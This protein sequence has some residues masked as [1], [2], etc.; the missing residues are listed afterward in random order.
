LVLGGIFLFSGSPCLG[1]GI[2]KPSVSTTRTVTTVVVHPETGK[3][4]RVRPG[5][6]PVSKKGRATTSRR[7]AQAKET[8]KKTPDVEKKE[9]HR[10]IE[11]TAKRHGV[12]PAL[13]HS[14]ISVESN[15]QQKA[16]SPKGARGL[17]QLIPETAERYGVANAFEP[18]QNL[19]GG[20]RYLKYLTTR[21]NGDLRLALA[22]Y[23]AGEGAV[24]RYGGIPP[25]RETQQYVT[26]VTGE[27]EAR[28]RK[29][30]GPLNDTPLATN[31]VEVAT[32][33]AG[34]T[35]ASKRQVSLRTYMD[36]NGRLHIETI[37][38]EESEEY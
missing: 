2:P 5:G 32:N 31:P 8:A 37:S 16:I 18:S 1:A 25:Y 15:Y 12:D 26:K 28:G 30:P 23:N 6:S 14:V 7:F 10:L 21:F 24:S 9:I 33:E 20:V 19:E 38:E 27:L 35:P 3:L 36:E 29:V 11:D 17:M 4:V 13:V 22:A 34:T